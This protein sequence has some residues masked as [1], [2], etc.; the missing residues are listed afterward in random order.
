MSSTFEHNLEKYAALAVEVGVNIQP[1]QTLVVMAPLFAAELARKVVKRAYE[2]GAKYVHVEW[3]DDTVTRTRFE[4]APAES[5][6]EY[7]IPFRAKGW[8]ELAENNAACQKHGRELLL[9]VIRVFSGD[10]KYRSG[11]RP[12]HWYHLTALW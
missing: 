6:K 1:G 2:K 9:H 4:L 12:F 8:V 10:L 7:P 5:F 11:D 3:N